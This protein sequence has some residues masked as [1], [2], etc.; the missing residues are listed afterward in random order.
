M[1]FQNKQ[2]IFLGLTVVITSLITINPM[3]DIEAQT[4]ELATSKTTLS[5]FYTDIHVVREIDT[6]NAN[7]RSV[8]AECP[9]GYVAFGGGFNTSHNPPGIRASVPIYESGVPYA[10]LSLYRD[11]TPGFWAE[12]RVVCAK[13]IETYIVATESVQAGHIPYQNTE[14]TAWC[15]NGDQLI[16]GTQTF[17]D[18]S[19]R[20]LIS[21][22]GKV[23]SNDKEGYS[24]FIN[25][26][27]NSL[28]QPF[29]VSAICLNTTL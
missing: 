11:L 10:W 27:P 17:L 14:V 1:T 7:P 20:V 29:S 6:G 19:K 18:P 15:E 13:P 5:T 24:A 25:T 12:S 8:L 28:E 16:G 26:L 9:E 2:K 22:T 4:T 21:A 23:E 3:I